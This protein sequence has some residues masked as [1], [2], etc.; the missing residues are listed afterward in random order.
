MENGRYK[1][2]NLLLIYF[3]L[4]FKLLKYYENIISNIVKKL[5]YYLSKFLGE[6][7]QTK[8]PTGTRTRR[9]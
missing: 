3:S 6:I 4:I 5:F 1:N 7:D 9:E 2:D 8:P